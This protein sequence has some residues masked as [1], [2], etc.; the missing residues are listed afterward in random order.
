MKHYLMRCIVRD[1]HTNEI[2]G[3]GQ[4]ITMCP[5]QAID[6]LRND[7]LWWEL[8]EKDVEVPDDD[9]GNPHSST[10]AFKPVNDLSELTG[11]KGR[12]GN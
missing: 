12:K 5:H 2:K 1:P 7:P 11:S 6:H 10:F 3:Y 4:P 9:R 8:V